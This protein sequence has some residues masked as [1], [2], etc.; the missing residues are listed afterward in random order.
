MIGKTVLSGDHSVLVLDKK[1][2]ELPAVQN[3]ID[4]HDAV[5]ISQLGHEPMDICPVSALPIQNTFGID[6]TT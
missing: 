4:T 5:T 2:F 6:R 3:E 1:F